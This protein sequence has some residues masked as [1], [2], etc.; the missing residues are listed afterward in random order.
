MPTSS[1]QRQCD[2]LKQVIKNSTIRLVCPICLQG[3]PRNDRLY[4]HFREKEDDTHQG[5]TK[6]KSDFPTFL[7]CYQV[8]LGALIPAE[9]IPID[10]GCFDIFF[11][12]E[13][14]GKDTEESLPRVSS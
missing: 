14:Y 4:S 3:F 13:N 10:S 11:V 12:V 8:S 1:L 9:G 6:R 7:L 2:A 5:L